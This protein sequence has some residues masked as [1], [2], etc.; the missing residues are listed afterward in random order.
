M[1]ALWRIIDV[2]RWTTEYF[3]KKGIETPR[4][5]AEVLIAHALG[6]DRLGLYLNYDSPLNDEERRR[7]REYI[8]RRASREP[9]H[10]ITGKRE[11][12]SL[13]FNVTPSVLIP[14]PETEI[15]VEA[16]LNC[17]VS[18]SYRRVVDVGTGSG[19]IAVALAHELPS[20]NV[21]ATD[22]SLEALLLARYNATRHGVKDR[23]DFVTM[24]LLEGFGKR[25]RF[26]MIVSNPP[27]LSD[28]EFKNLPPEIRSYEPARAL[29]G[30]GPDGLDTVRRL[31]QQAVPFLKPGG[32]LCFEIGA[33]QL[34][35][36]LNYAASIK[37]FT[38]STVL[39]DYLG[40]PR[41]VCLEKRG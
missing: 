19:A 12:W 26:D 30:G 40:I 21:I 29:L 25:A 18:R 41:V 10:Y 34:D 5:D 23:I 39:E 35:K 17:I 11:F 4:L 6:T 9:V 20:L 7:I 33:G 16:A 15:L 3:K 37:E 31:L 38:G 22:I 2:L 8:K 27:Y 14:R 28:V 13:E 32:M 1:A 24:D 36:V